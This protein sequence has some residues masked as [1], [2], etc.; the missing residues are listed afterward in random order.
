MARRRRPSATRPQR[1]SAAPPADLPVEAS[2]DAQV[3]ASNLSLHDL[4]QQQMRTMLDGTDLD[5]ETRQSIFVAASCPCCGGGG[6]S[7]TAKLKRRT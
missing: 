5:E 1:S 4:F 2:G 3:E 6:M 7:F